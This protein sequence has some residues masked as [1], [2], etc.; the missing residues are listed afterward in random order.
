MGRHARPGLPD[1]PS[2]AAPSIDPDDPLAPYHRRRCAP[3]DVYRR[4]RPVC[5]G[6]THVRP[7]EPRVLEPWDGFAYVPEGTAPNLAASQAWAA[8]GPAPGG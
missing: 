7:E 6:A 3:M 4:H 1:Q 5:G 2:R 8:G